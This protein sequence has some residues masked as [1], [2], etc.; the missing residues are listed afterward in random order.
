[1][2]GRLLA[3]AQAATRS[4]CGVTSQREPTANSL[5]AQLHVFISVGEDDVP[6]LVQASEVA[7]QHP[8]ILDLYLHNRR[9]REARRLGRSPAGGVTAAACTHVWRCVGGMAGW[10]AEGA[11]SPCTACAA[12][13]RPARR[14]VSAAAAPCRRRRRCSDLRRA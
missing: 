13:L 14:V 5:A 4:S 3:V 9:A 8:P 12:A 1:M 2:H 6:L 7:N 11:P 10:L